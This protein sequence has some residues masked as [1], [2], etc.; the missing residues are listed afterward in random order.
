MD[1]EVKFSKG[2]TVKVTLTTTVKEAHDGYCNVFFPWIESEHAS[3]PNESLTLVAKHYPDGYYKDNS[4]SVWYRH[5][6]GDWT[7]VGH[8]GCG[9]YVVRTEPSEDG[10]KRLVAEN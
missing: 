10:L 3:F 1:K 4:G 2:D 8:P 9:V 5:F 7:F 6:S